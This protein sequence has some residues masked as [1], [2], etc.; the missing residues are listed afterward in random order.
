MYNL[1]VTG[2]AENWQ[3]DPWTTDRSRCVREYTAQDVIEMFGSLDAA[4]IA[5]LRKFPCIFAFETPCNQ[6]PKFGKITTVTPTERHVRIEYAFEDVTPYITHD[7]LVEHATDL[8]IERWELNRSHWAV[9]EVNLSKVLK[10]IGVTLPTWATTLSQAVNIMT[11]HFE[12]GLSF[13]G[14]ARTLV[15]PVARELERIIGPNSYFY[16]N[17]YTA[18]LARPSLDVLLQGIYGQRSKLLVVFLSADYQRKRWC[19][20]EFRAIREIIMNR[21][22]ERIMYVR[23]DDGEVDGVFDTDGYV[24]GRNFTPAEIAGMI[25]ER[26]ELLP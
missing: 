12:V 15:E 20:V 16:D 6:E 8:G 26:V 21:A 5:K 11:H 19:N 22:E 2:N 24:D 10:K 17:N 14:E 23:M 13:P 3:G 18:Q 25:K 7:D 9:K 1:L 4:A